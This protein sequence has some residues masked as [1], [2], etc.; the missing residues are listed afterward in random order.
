MDPALLRTLLSLPGTRRE[1]VA[2]AKLFDAKDT[3]VR[4][5]ADATERA[6]K[7]DRSVDRAEV[8]VFATHGLLPRELGGLE[9]PA[10]VLTPPSAATAIDDGVLT[11]SE[12]AQLSLTAEWVILSACNTAG[13]DTADGGESLSGLSRAFL[14]AGA[15]AVLASHWRVQ[16]DVTAALTVQTLQARRDQPGLGKA[17]ALQLAMRAVRTGTGVDGQPIP[18][19]KPAWALPSAWAPFVVVETR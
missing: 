13:G 7:S 17:D 10:L 2:M 3:V 12:V 5:G 14:Y 9:E 19:W 8:L 6:L 1:L 4:F 18:G 16:D 11:A 15:R